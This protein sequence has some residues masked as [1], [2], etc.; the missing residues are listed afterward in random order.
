MLM[1]MPM[2][3]PRGGTCLVRLLLAVCHKAACWL[4]VRLKRM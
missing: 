3:E 2:A 1:L 4:A